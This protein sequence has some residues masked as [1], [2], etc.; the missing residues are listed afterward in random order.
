MAAL[1][2]VV[3]FAAPF[4]TLRAEETS[5]AF[6][7]ASSAA[8]PAALPAGLS[9]N[10]ARA[11]AL[12]QNSDFRIAQIQVDAALAQLRVAREFPNPTLGL[13]TAKISTDGTPEGTPL[14]NQLYNR[15]YDSIVSLSQLFQVAKRGLLRDAATAG[16]HAA[17]FQR[18]D[19][20]RLLVQAVTQAYAAALSARAQAEVLAES[21][22]KLRHEADI[23]AHRYQAGDLSASDRT[24]L[25][26]AAEQDELGAEVE[27]ATALAS[28]V[29][30]ETLLGQP[31]PDGATRLTDTLDSLLRETP[32]DLAAASVESRPDVAAAAESVRQAEANLT[33]QRRQRIPD[34]TVSVQYERNPPGQTNTVGLGVSLPLP[35]WNRSNGEILA[36]QAARA[37]AQA[38]LDKVRIQMSSEVASA[39][40]AYREA[41]ARAERYRGSLLPKSREATRSVSYAFDKG[42]AT[43]VD[44]LEAERSDNAIRV[45]AVQADADTAVAGVALLSALGRLSASGAE[46]G[47]S[48]GGA[49]AR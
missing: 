45:A 25:E 48:G 9:L 39:R 27:R 19:A 3:V 20:R 8:L 10:E 41:A 33:L 1:G 14:G 15:A 13:S 26:I 18:E 36:A 17:Q 35:L 12:R 2:L 49:M 47:A 34:V 44:L 23:A 6:P 42:G 5:A 11:R 46:G 38:Q 4:W 28:V 43:L 40:V 24:R 31:K 29:A 16:L 32:P 37:Q 30:L 22:G 7:A 21:A